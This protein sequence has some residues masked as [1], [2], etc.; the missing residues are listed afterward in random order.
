MS[1]MRACN[2]Q[3]LYLL[4]EHLDRSVIVLSPHAAAVFRERMQQVLGTSQRIGLANSPCGFFSGET[5]EEI[6]RQ[7]TE[8]FRSLH[9]PVTVEQHSSHWSVYVDVPQ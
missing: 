6:V 5:V 9:L 4:M 7:A 3:D 8:V 2:A 1:A